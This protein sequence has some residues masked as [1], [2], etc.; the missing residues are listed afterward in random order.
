MTT[1]NKQHFLL[2]QHTKLRFLSEVLH[3]LQIIFNANQ[4][5]GCQSNWVLSDIT[6]TH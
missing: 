4:P 6:N 1:I 5:L 3:D 2:N